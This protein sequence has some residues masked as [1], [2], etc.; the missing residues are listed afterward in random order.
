VPCDTDSVF[1]Q[2]FTL[3]NSFRLSI[4]RLYSSLVAASGYYNGGVVG[5]EVNTR[6]NILWLLEVWNGPTE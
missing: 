2:S 6:K 5:Q 1:V 3:K 4:K